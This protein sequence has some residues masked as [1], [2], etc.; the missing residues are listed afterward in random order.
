MEYK[1][2]DMGKYDAVTITVQVMSEDSISII[3]NLVII[4]CYEPGSYTE[5][6]KLKFL[7]IAISGICL[8]IFQGSHGSHQAAPEP[9]CWPTMTQ[10]GH[11]HATQCISLV[12]ADAL[13]IVPQ[14]LLCH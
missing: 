7:F 14:N 2:D 4:V 5:A 1:A 12:H 3:S 11:E 6:L 9:M 8:G 13:H 10:A